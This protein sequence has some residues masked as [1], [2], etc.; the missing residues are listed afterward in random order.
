[1]C[2]PRQPD[3]LA[4]AYFGLAAGR[5]WTIFAKWLVVMD[6]EASSAA[7]M[8]FLARILVA[9]IGLTNVLLSTV[10]SADAP[11]QLASVIRGLRRA[12][13]KSSAWA[14]RGADVRQRSGVGGRSF[15]LGR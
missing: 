10:S 13:A 4:F 2:V 9:V 1:M 7:M 11:K 14:I 8:A 5:R 6:T 3:A 12:V 15:A